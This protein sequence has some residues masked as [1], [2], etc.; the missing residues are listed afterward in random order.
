MTDAWDE[1]H[2]D[3]KPPVRPTHGG[4]REEN[5][6]RERSASKKR[7]RSIKERLEKQRRI[8]KPK[9]DPH[10]ISKKLKKS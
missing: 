5:L 9:V 10:K 8:E 3:P 7:T 4:R 6:C 1:Q 2:G